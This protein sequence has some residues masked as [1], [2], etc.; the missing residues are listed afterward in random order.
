MQIVQIYIL[1]IILILFVFKSVKRKTLNP[2]NE[3]VSR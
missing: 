3:L 2:N 1:K